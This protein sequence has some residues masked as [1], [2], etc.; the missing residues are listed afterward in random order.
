MKFKITIQNKD[1]LF[2]NEQLTILLDMLHGADVLSSEY[3][4]SGKGDGGTNYIRTVRPLETTDINMSAVSD[5]YVETMR[6]KT[7]LWDEDKNK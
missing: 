5:D 1:V 4:G 2:T 7:K 3:V 6:L